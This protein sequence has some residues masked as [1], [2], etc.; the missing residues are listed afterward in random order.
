MYACRYGLLPVSIPGCSNSVVVELSLLMRRGIAVRAMKT[1][2]L[3]G[4]S[5]VD[6]YNLTST[7]VRN[8]NNNHAYLRATATTIERDVLLIMQP[9]NWPLVVTC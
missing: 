1:K 5:G 8:Q 7:D 4:D 9:W 6:I 3:D 2:Q